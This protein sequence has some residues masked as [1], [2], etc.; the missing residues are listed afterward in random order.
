M[1]NIIELVIKDFKLLFRNKS[2]TLIFIL[3][4]LLVVLILGFAFNSADLYGLK[5]ATYSQQ[6]SPLTDGLLNKLSSQFTIIKTANQQACIDGV[7]LSE[8]HVCLIF[9]RN[10]DIKGN[11][12]IDF[13]VNPTKMNLVYIITNLI[14]AKVGEQTTEI[15]KGL[16]E[17]LLKKMEFVKAEVDK[18]K[19]LLSKI[20][21]ATAS[22]KEISSGLRDEFSSLNLNFNETAL[23]TTGIEGHLNA[24][25]ASATKIRAAK[26]NISEPEIQAIISTAYSNISS[27]LSILESSVGELGDAVNSAKDTLKN[28]NETQAAAKTGLTTALQQLNTALEDINSMSAS[29]SL[30]GQELVVGLDASK[31]VKPITT[32]IKEVTTEKRYIGLIFPILLVM[33]LMF[34]GIF[35]GSS[36]VISEKTSR[37]YFRNLIVPVRRITFV[38]SAYITTMIV[39]ALETGIIMGVVYFFTKTAIMPSLIVS[40]ALIASV[41]VSIGLL[42]GYVSRNSEVAMLISIAIVA[43]FMFF[44]NLILPIETIAY[45]KEIAVYNPFTIASNILKESMLLSIGYKAHLKYLAILFSYL[46]IAFMASLLAQKLNKKHA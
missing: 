8:W 6:Y 17:E 3:G 22:I 38:I 35:F 14:S 36:M 2:S 45:L 15:S 41:F 46:A 24:L 12:N 19:I 10:F 32:S 34:G 16:V 37:A 29:F 23:N 7:K 39:L 21:T 44:S 11:S 13:Y 18:D 1:K 42:I 9:P 26:E 31:L 30:I 28:A 4:P 20:S 27:E 5:L 25:R 43:L 33:M 40:L